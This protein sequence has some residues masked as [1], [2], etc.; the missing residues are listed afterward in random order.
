M[1]GIQ[2]RAENIIIIVAQN[3]FKIATGISPTFVQDNHSKSTQGVLRGLHYQ[4]PPKAQEKLVRVIQGE[5]YDVVVDIRKD[6]P[7]FGQWLGEVLTG[8]NKKQLWIPSGFAHGFLVL[9]ETAE[10]LYKA[11]HFYAPKS[12]RCIVWNDPTIRIDWPIHGEPILSDKDQHGLPL[13]EADL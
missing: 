2:F 3:N 5:I 11:T 12:E 1:T 8:H 10:V 7:T 4:L 6:S 13:N 9:S